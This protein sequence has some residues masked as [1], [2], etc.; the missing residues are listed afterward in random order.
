MGSTL[1]KLCEVYKSQTSP[2]CPHTPYGM[3]SDPTQIQEMLAKIV[4]LVMGE[5]GTHVLHRLI[6]QRARTLHVDVGNYTFS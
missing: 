5:F 1:W 4:S 6:Y 2:I 3:I